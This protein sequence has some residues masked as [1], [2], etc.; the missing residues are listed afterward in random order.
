MSVVPLRFVDTTLRDGEQAAGVSFTRRQKQ[1]IARLL[2]AAGI[3]ELEVGIP[4]MGGDEIDDIRAVADL[5]LPARVMPWCRAL[6][7][8]LD[9]AV[10]CGVDAIHVS[11]PVSLRHLGAINKTSD[12]VLKSLGPLLRQARDAFGFVS[13][14]SQDAS[15]ADPSLLREF[16]HAA[17]EAGASRVRIADTVGI[18]DPLHTFA[19]FSDLRCQKG[20]PPLEFHGHND[21]GMATA[22]TLAAIQ[23]GAQAVSV[24]VNGMGERAGNAALEEVAVALQVSVGVD[25]GIDTSGFWRLCAY[26]ASASKRPIPRQ[27]PVVGE[28]AF[29][30]ESGIHCHAMLRDRACYQAFDPADIG[31]P[32]Q[33]FAIGRHSGRASLCDRLLQL[34]VAVPQSSAGPLLDRV[35]R[36][37]TH[38]RRSLTDAELLTLAT[39]VA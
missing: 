20:C 12:W 11:W 21:L 22:N 19:M 39:E 36:Q 3:P 17:G 7:G 5:G 37:A 26:V 10:R 8:D 33:P 15:R 23:A 24:T 30:H 2:S 35:R 38:L 4:A 16:V 27:K 28:A 25:C 29:L 13:V 34:G 31:R 9:A 6:G 14:G 1:R 18:L 32:T